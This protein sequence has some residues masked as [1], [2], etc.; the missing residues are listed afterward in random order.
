MS[1]HNNIPSTI[2][3]FYHYLVVV[4][5]LFDLKENQKIIIEVY[6]DITK[7][8][9]D[10]E[11]FLENIEVKYHQDENTLNYA[12]EDFWKTIKN[13]V[14]DIGKYN[15]K[16]KLIL[17]TT[18][19]LGID[20]KNN[21]IKTVD[22]KLNTINI[23]KEKTGNKKIRSHFKKI[24][25]DEEI[26]KKVLDKVLFV[27][28]KIDYLDKKKA[29]IEN[30]KDYFDSFGDNENIKISAIEKFR[31]LIIEKLENKDNWEIDFDTFRDVRNEFLYKNEPKNK[32]IEENEILEVNKEYIKTDI[33]NEKLYIK[34]LKDIEFED[35]ELFE[36][37]KNKYR[38]LNFINQL[39]NHK[40]TF[41]SE[42]I[43]NCKIVFINQWKSKK[44]KYHRKS[45]KDGTFQSSQNLYDELIDT[46]KLCL[47]DEDKT[48]SFRKGYWHILADDDEKPKQIY[49]MIGDKN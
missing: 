24:F 19:I 6:G 21:H 49:W 40:K 27:S 7:A 36:A 32:T 39:M 33:S 44:A 12:N 38:A 2:G 26:L 23:W 34:K 10:T 8:T 11:L 14:K 48:Q 28:N 13:W 25:E 15:D 3:N 41:Y 30:H 47:F 37:G 29:I 31:S 35:D 18:S 1:E 46:E 5:K 43:T 22:E 4:D 20:L 17:D 45:K 16:T 42:K 9:I